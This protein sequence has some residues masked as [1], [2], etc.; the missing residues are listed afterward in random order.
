MQKEKYSLASR[1]RPSKMKRI[2]GRLWEVVA[3]KNRITG[4]PLPRRG[5]GTSTL[6]KKIYYMQFLSYA[7]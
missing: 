1:N 6:L 2:S 4:G 7:M 3:F 5:L